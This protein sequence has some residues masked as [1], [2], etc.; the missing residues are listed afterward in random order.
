MKIF[1]G[2]Y[3]WVMTK[4]QH[5]H[6]PT[7]LAA[8]SF[9]ESVI[10]PI[11]PDVMLAPMSLAQTAKAWRYAT[12]TTIASIIG[13]ALGY[14]LGYLLFDPLVVP[15]IES[16]GKMDKFNLVVDWFEQYGVWVVFIAGFS[17]IPYKLFT[18]GAGVLSMAFLP[19][20]LASAVG[21]GMRF[22]LVAGLMV[23]GGAAMEQKLRQYVEVLGWLVVALGVVLY[24]VLKH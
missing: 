5:R 13:G 15:V 23:W 9:T 22:F 7:Y 14:L 19:F 6:A 17:P 18:V 2:M 24:L 4:V 10:F 12:I 21:R 11:P 1:T 16:M 3:D 20:M 8:L